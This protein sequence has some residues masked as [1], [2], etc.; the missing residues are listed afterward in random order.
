MNHG[1]PW[2]ITPPN[3]EMLFIKLNLCTQD[4]P[5]EA[6]KKLCAVYLY[7]MFEHMERENTANQR[8]LIDEKFL[9]QKR[10]QKCVTN[11]FII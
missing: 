2:V 3:T 9:I 6:E 10:N 8:T 7:A 1:Q 5:R 4:V 11:N